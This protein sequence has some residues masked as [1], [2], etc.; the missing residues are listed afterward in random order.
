VA[1]GADISFLNS[2]STFQSL[3]ATA[4]Q[5]ITF[6]AGRTL[7]AVAA[8]G[9]LTL[10]ASNGQ[11]SDAGA[12]TLNAKNG[13]T[14]N[15]DLTTGGILT[16]NADT[17]ASGAGTFTVASGKTVDTTNTALNITAAD[18]DLQGSLTSGSATTTIT[19]AKNE[20]IGLG[21]TAGDLTIDG[22]ELSHITAATLVLGSGTTTGI[23]VDGRGRPWVTNSLAGTVSLIDPA[24]GTV[25]QTVQ[26]GHTPTSIAYGGGLLWVTVQAG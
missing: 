23:T 5:D 18:V 6:D 21:Q 14:L 9:S 15:S 8:T 16:V 22:T 24:A 10:T 26:L 20:T 19:T 25:T 7:S 12:L 17:D 3:T 2:N 13:I 1:A 11:I 4:D